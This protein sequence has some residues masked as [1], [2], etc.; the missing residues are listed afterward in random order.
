MTQKAKEALSEHPQRK[1][2]AFP[3]APATDIRGGQARGGEL[4]PSSERDR[5][6]DR[7]GRSDKHTPFIARLPCCLLP[8]VLP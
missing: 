8:L 6:Y 3:E 1:S 7:D 4:A 2:V 5:S